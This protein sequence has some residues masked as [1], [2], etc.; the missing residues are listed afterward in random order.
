MAI[1]MTAATSTAMPMMNGSQPEMPMKPMIS[2][3]A[4]KEADSNEA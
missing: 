1:G 4:P 2:G 3:P